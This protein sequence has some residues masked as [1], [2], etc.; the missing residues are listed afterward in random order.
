MVSLQITD[1]IFSILLLLI[2]SLLELIRDL[3]LEFISALILVLQLLV[4]VLEVLHSQLVSVDFLVFVLK[5]RVHGV[6]DITVLVCKLFGVRFEFDLEMGALLDRLL[7]LRL[8]LNILKLELKLFDL[9]FFGL[10]LCLHALSDLSLNL[11][12]QS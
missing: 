2:K 7:S 5:L 3:L 9:S 12:E 6:H 8:S 10:G 11:C 1:L 4:L